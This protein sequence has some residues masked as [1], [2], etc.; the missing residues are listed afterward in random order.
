MTEERPT[1]FPDYLKSVTGKASGGRLMLVWTGAVLV[2]LLASLIW[3]PAALI[4]PMT[5]F[6]LYVAG[7]AAFHYG[8]LPEKA[9]RTT[10]QTTRDM[11]AHTAAALA[12]TICALLLAIIAIGLWR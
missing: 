12:I 2:W 10:E 8:M 1:T 9:E 3:Q 7:A 5:A 4:I 6:G 11:R